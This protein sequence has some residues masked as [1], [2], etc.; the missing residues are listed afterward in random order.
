MGRL[1][2]RRNGGQSTVSVVAVVL[3]SCTV[4]AV[5]AAAALTTF[6]CLSLVSPLLLHS[7]FI[8]LFVGP[9]I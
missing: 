7:S 8:S 6:S 9:L 5:S 4:F 2:R 1:I 3:V